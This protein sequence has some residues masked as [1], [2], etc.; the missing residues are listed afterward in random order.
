MAVDKA[1]EDAAA[2]KVAQDKAAEEAG[3]S[4]TAGAQRTKVASGKIELDD[5]QKD[6]CKQMGISAEDYIKW[7][8]VGVS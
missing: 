4:L 2:Q 1:A 7:A 6:I 3:A 8:K 5:T